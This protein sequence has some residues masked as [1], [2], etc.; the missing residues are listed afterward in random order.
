MTEYSVVASGDDLWWYE[1]SYSLTDQGTLLIGYIYGKIHNLMRFRN[2]TIPDGYTIDSAYLLLNITDKVDDTPSCTIYAV[3]ADSPSL[4]TD[5]ASAEALPLTTA[6]VAF[7][8]PSIGSYQS[9]SLVSIIEEV[10]ASRSFASGRDLFIVIK[11]NAGVSCEVVYAD[12]YDEEAEYK[13]VPKLVI[14]ASAPSGSSWAGTW[15]G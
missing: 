14:T 1:T 8:N 5:Y 4:P 12:S 9:A 7:G 2:V 3:D 11:C 6:G 13:V 15:G 10:M